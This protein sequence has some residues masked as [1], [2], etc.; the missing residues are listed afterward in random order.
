[1][2]T[3]RAACALLIYR[4]AFRFDES[5]TGTNPY[6]PKYLLRNYA[7]REG[8]YGVTVRAPLG[9]IRIKADLESNVAALLDTSYPSHH[10]ELASR[11]KQNRRLV[12]RTG[13]GREGPFGLLCHLRLGDS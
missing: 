5:R 8:D 6:L 12:A 11:C 2:K 4:C 1:M 10:R 3:N 7:K 9:I 13:D